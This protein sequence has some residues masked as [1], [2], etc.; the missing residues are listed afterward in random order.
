MKRSILFLAVLAALL[1]PAGAF[2]SGVVLKVQ[3]ASHL[4]AVS[5]SATRVSLVHTSVAARLRVG[6]RV[7]LT[8]RRLGNGTLS[9]TRIRVVGRAHTVRFRGL[10]LV[11]THTHLLVSAG[12]AVL[13]IRRGS[14]FTSSSR[15]SL[16]PVGSQIAVQ[17]TFGAHDELDEDDVVVVAPMAP[18]GS[19]EGHLTLGMTTVTISSE[20]MTLVLNVPPGFDLTRFATGDE[21]FATFSQPPDGTLTLTKLARDDDDNRDDDHGGDR[22]GDGGHHGGDGGGG[23]SGSHHD[24]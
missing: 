8:A 12:G 14:R 21:V 2:A 24:G 16:P 20:H 3:P 6:Q 9:A 11:R 23:G 10:L 4:V 22:G 7:A 18:G 5:R 15:D 19:L 17:A 13:S 1:A